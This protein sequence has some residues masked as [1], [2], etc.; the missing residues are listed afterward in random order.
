MTRA[1]TEAIA[2]TRVEIWEELVCDPGMRVE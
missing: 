2:N 1:E